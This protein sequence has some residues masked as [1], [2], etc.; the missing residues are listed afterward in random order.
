MKLDDLSRYRALEERYICVSEQLEGKL[1]VHDTVTGDSGA[2]AYSKVT[3]P[4]EGYIH[5]VGTVTLLREQ[6]DLLR[7][8]QMIEDY[9]SAI[10]LQ[11]Y[12]RA[13]E[14]YCCDTSRKWTWNQIQEKLNITGDLRRNIANYL[15]KI[16]E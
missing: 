16:S 11:K 9:I 8:M 6:S 14:L 2:P 5:G 3:K 10:P 13:L 12:R 7:A 4:V 15:S 1:R